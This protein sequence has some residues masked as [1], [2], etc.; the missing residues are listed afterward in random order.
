MTKAWL[1]VEGEHDL[2]VL[3]DFYGRELERARIRT[4]AT[5]G[6]GRA[7]A[8][9]THLE[10]LAP[11]G[12]PFFYLSDN[13]RAEAVMTGQLSADRM[14]QEEF[15]VEQLGRFADEKGVNL[16]ILGLPDPD[17][18]CALPIEAIRQVVGENGGKPERATSWRELIEA[19]VCH[20]EDARARDE[21]PLTFKPFVF[22]TLGLRNLGADQFVRDALRIANGQPSPA[23]PLSRL[24]T[25]VVAAVGRGSAGHV[26]SLPS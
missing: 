14:T 20:Q 12:M 10:A 24:V 21:K 15:L 19:H 16:K 18:I 22:E 5:R 8:S 13:A 2:M 11:H 9:I 6:G 1:L 3:N 25:E 26:Q 7:K 23:S 4:L 17:I